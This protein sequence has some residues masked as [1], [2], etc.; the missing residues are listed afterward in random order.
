[1]NGPASRLPTVDALL[2]PPG[3]AL[4]ARIGPHPLPPDAALRLGTALRRDYPPDLVAAAFTLHD[5]RL[6]AAAKFSR[7]DAMLFTR[8]GLEQATA[9]PAARHRAARFAGATRIADLCCGIGGDL[10][11]L[12]AIAPVLAVDRDPVHLRI[13]AHNAAVYDLAEHVTPLEADVQSLDLTGIAGLDAVFIDPARR[14]LDR[15][16]GPNLTEPPLPWCL[17]LAARVPAVAIKAAPGIDPDRTPPGWEIEFVADERDLKE[18]V[19]WS[20][21]LAQTARRATILPLGHTLLPLPGDPVPILPPGAYLLDPNPAVTRAGLVEDLARGLGAWKIDDQ[22]AFLCTDR[23][24]R[25]PFARTL[26]V[27][28]SL[29]WRH[30][31]IAARLRTVGIGSIDIRRRGLPGDVEEIRRR[32]KLRGPGRATLAMTRAGD[33]PWCLIC[34]DPD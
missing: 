11:A 25:T 33:K 12:A 24:V 13:A 4:L 17:D 5:L 6:R 30:R 32:L 22:I 7:A 19:L 28:D 1:M 9:E 18:S 14:T 29:P 21:A 27:L 3:Q 10:I 8:P 2:S 31:E 23:D 15:R 26:R 16:L 20:P 34:V